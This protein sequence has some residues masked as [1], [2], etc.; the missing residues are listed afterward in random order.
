MKYYQS[1]RKTNWLLLTNHQL[2]SMQFL[3]YL[4]LSN[5]IIFKERRSKEII[6]KLLLLIL[7]RK[8]QEYPLVELMIFFSRI[9]PTKG[10][11]NYLHLK[12]K[13]WFLHHFIHFLTLKDYVPLIPNRANEI[14]VYSN[15]SYLHLLRNL[16]KVIT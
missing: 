6:H 2:N 9:Q 14:K 1:K 3:I 5:L 10:V 12:N 11:S 7:E 8:H 4:L 16:I 13:I 15:R